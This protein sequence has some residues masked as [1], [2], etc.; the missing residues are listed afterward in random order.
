MNIYT[1]IL[2]GE[3]NTSGLVSF[4]DK[5]WKILLLFRKWNLHGSCRESFP[6]FD[7]TIFLLRFLR[8][9]FRV[10][11]PDKIEI[12]F[13]LLKQSVLSVVYFSII[14]RHIPSQYI[15]WY[16]IAPYCI[17]W[18]ASKMTSSEMGRYTGTRQFVCCEGVVTTI[19]DR[20]YS[21]SKR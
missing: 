20:P 7:D 2:I 17:I 1:L 3:N 19:L 16:C 15:E 9:H 21:K 11:A 5:K 8:T 4:I 18:H 10:W 12:K 13:L 14:S 6:F